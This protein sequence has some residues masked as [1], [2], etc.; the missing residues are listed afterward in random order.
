MEGELRWE[1]K[2]IKIV[3][4]SKTPIIQNIYSF[5][6]FTDF[7]GS[8]GLN[9]LEVNGNKADKTCWWHT[10]DITVWMPHEIYFVAD[11]IYSKWIYK[12]IK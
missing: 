9:G 8:L 11:K 4:M 3:K 2:S 7:S 12:N 1:G 10:Y 6:K 5:V